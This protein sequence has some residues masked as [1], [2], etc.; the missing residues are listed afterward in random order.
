APFGWW[1]RAWRESFRTEH[2]RDF[3]RLVVALAWQIL[4]F[5]LPMGL[6]LGLWSA[7]L[8]AAAVWAALFYYLVRDAHSV[9]TGVNPT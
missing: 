3:V 8:P 6:V 9:G 7:V 4:T 1:P 5:L 2:R